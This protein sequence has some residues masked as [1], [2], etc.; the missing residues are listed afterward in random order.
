VRPW[1]VRRIAVVGAESTG[2]S[3]LCAR[4]REQFKTLVVPEWTRVLVE[5]MPGGL[6]SDQ[7]QL[8]ARSQIA[9][10]DALANQLPDANAGIM[11]CDTELRTIWLWTQRLFDGDPPA[12]IREQIRKRPY[13]LY[14]LCAPD[15][16]YVG[17]SEWDRPEDRRK[18]DHALRAELEGANVVEVA[19]TREERFQIAAD[20]VISL[21]TPKRLLPERALYMT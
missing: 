10:E 6:S 18:F 15:V 14:L 13:D 7:I 17:L 21:F 20:A 5:T 4:L 16:P 2:K 8:A 9:S 1:F 11:L 3:T 19:G 12:W